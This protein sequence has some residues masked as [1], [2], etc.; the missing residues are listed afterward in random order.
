MLKYRY[1]FAVLAVALLLASRGALDAQELNPASVKGNMSVQLPK[2]WVEEATA[3]NTLLVAGAPQKDK[4]ATGEKAASLSITVT[5]NAKIDPA[6]LKKELS[7]A[8][9]L[10]IRMANR[11]P[12]SRSNGLQGVMV[13]GTVIKQGVVLQSRQ[14]FFVQ[15]N[16]RYAITFTCLKSRFAAYRETIEAS[17]GTVKVAR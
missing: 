14:Y 11:W 7:A 5:D 4:D 3:G 8:A 10:Q 2:G 16:Q 15:N 13:G 1:N 17:I 6:A 9:R 12:S